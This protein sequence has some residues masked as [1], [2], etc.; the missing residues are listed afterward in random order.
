MCIFVGLDLGSKSNRFELSNENGQ[1]KKRGKLTWSE[2]EWRELLEEY[3]GE[4]VIVAFE[5]C[6]E[7]YRAKRILEKMEIEYYPFHSKSFLSVWSSKKKTDRIDASKIRRA[8]QAGSLPERV[9]LPD[10]EEAL[11]RNLITQRELFQKMLVQLCLQAK[12]MGRQWGA[13]LP[14]YTREEFE[15][16]WDKAIET[17]PGTCRPAAIRNHRVALTLCQAMDE[18]EEK[19][20]HQ[21]DRTQQGERVKSLM[22]VPGVGKVIAPAIIAYLGDAQRFPSAR[23]FASYVGLTPVVDQTGNREA[24]LGHISKEGPSILRRLFVQAARIAARSKQLEK[25]PLRKWHDRI[26]NR[27]GKKIATVSLARKLAEVC[28][29]IIRDGTVWDPS[30]LRSTNP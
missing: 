8:L 25:T 20:E 28:Y 7:A 17:L 14:K 26:M 12:G 23:K 5:T 24:R 11:L 2:E 9:H 10:D 3:S 30:R 22:T 27:R 21:V 16:W 29:A 15:S 19:I 13:V 4:R 18:L 6:P 1:G